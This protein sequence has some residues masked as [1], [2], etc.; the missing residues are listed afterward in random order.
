MSV[1][2]VISR[3]GSPIDAPGSGAHPL[4][5]GGRLGVI[6]LLV[7]ALVAFA[8]APMVLPASYSWV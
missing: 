1:S 6:V 7:A 3:P 2:S 4:P 5:P 8:L